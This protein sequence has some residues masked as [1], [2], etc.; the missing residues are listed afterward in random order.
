MRE[1]RT[2]SRLIEEGRAAVPMSGFYEPSSMRAAGRQAFFRPAGGT[3]LALALLD[4]A[5]GQFVILTQ[6]SA[7]AVAPHHPRMPVLA[8]P[9]QVSRWLQ[10]GAIEDGA[11]PLLVDLPV[12]TRP[13]G[14]RDP[15]PQEDYVQ[16]LL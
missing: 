1:R 6:D 10:A 3:L 9:E 13:S 7:G 4:P 16:R 2:F 14:D 11:P 8:G 15:S 5:R 12:A